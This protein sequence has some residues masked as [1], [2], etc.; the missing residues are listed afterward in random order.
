M[1]KKTEFLFLSEEDMIKAGVLDAEKCVDCLDEMFRLLGQGDY[2]MGGASHNE[3]GIRIA[4][5]DEPQFE[6]MPAN[7]PDRRF[8]AMPA[9]L[10]GRF[11][12]AGEK[13][14]GSNIVNPSRGLPRSI[15]MVM[16]ND[17][18]TGEPV[19]LCS[20]NL[21]SAIRTG[22][23]PGVAVRYLARKDSTAMGLVGAGP[24]QRACV[25]GMMADAKNIKT[26]Y[27][28]DI[29]PE[30]AEKL[31]A[32]AKE[33]YGVD[34][35]V[36]GSMEEA[37]RP[38][39]IVSFATSRLRPVNVKEERIKEGATLIFTGAAKIEEKLLLEG[40]VYFDNEKLHAAAIDECHADP[41]GLEAAYDYNMTGSVYRL[42]E[43][44]K[45]PPVLDMP[46]LGGCACG[47][48]P[49]RTND[50]DRIC[51]MTGGMAVE[52]LAWCHDLV[53]RA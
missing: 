18:D 25:Q 14:Y 48:D 38:S 44:G 24:I 29:N 6:G 41:K 49:G 40:K 28:F 43:N 20:G 53:E 15:L 35:V 10:G 50:K 42:I 7:G 2:I 12:I 30:A 3:H 21:A 51:V 36:C 34:F 19:A 46:S 5:P 23:V 1:G 37:L 52:D 45:L 33:T 8:M 32:W 17:V 11:H 31:G 39:D 13:W 26:M 27:C 9:Y 47:R 16:L 22:A 4:F